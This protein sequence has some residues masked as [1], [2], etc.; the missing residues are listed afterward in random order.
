MPGGGGGNFFQHAVNVHH[1]ELFYYVAK[2]GGISAAVRQIPYGI[3]QPA[4]SGQ[5][6]QLE[7]DVGAKLF[8][9]SPFR[10]TQA[11]EKLFAHVEPFFNQL[12][13][14]ANQLKHDAHPE[15]RIGAS[16]IALRD[17]IPAVIRRVKKQ[18]PKIRLSLRT[19]YQSQLEDWLREGQ[20]DLAITPITSRPPA[21]LKSSA[22]VLA[23]LVLLV[24]KT[25][26]LKTAE[27]LW[28]L[29]K[30]TEPLVSLPATSAI[31]QTF[32]R[33]LKRR[34][35]SWPQSVEATSVEVIHRY[36]AAGDGVGVS[37]ALAS[38]ASERQI[39]SL[40]IDGFEPMTLGILW[41]GEPSDLTRAVMD[42]AHRYAQETWPQWAAPVE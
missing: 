15:I 17:H 1:L 16:D 11:G 30:I 20:L 28:A 32:Q 7:E 18:F 42:E 21:R 10:L 23:P 31:M 4:V 14:L 12:P 26:P 33:D 22:L 8:E 2:S 40:V 25:S 36:V 9:R 13:Q 29:K 37:L 34:G 24:P 5:M 39:R 3:Q 27:S 41:H 6:R 38:T 19:G 35:V